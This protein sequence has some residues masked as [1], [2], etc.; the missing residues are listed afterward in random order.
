MCALQFKSEH[1]E[2][3]RH[4]ILIERKPLLF[5]STMSKEMNLFYTSFSDHISH[6]NKGSSNDKDCIP[7]RVQT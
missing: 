1:T 2:S 4:E 3:Y 5:G 6:S 7:V